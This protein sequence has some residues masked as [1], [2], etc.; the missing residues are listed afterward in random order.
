MSR[1]LT[2]IEA[3][4]IFAVVEDVVEKLELIEK[5]MPDVMR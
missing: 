5:I 2:Q 1:K 4:R 3:Q